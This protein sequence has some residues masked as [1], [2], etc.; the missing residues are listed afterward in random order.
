MLR[1]GRLV[2]CRK[3]SHRTK[4]ESRS[5]S[6]MGFARMH[7]GLDLESMGSKRLYLWAVAGVVVGPRVGRNGAGPDTLHR[8]RLS[9][10]L[11]IVGIRCSD[12]RL[13]T[14]P[15]YSRERSLL[16]SLPELHKLHTADISTAS[17]VTS[18]DDSVQMLAFLW[19]QGGHAC[20]KA[21]GC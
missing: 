6:R 2:I 10:T 11:S 9:S 8:G 3:C 19:R 15:V 16:H 4:P 13:L 12:G 14:T 5:V 7:Y 18:C 20:V 21:T 17:I 1:R